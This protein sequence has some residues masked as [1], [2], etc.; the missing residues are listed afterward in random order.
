MTSDAEIKTYCKQ[1]TANLEK[2]AEDEFNEFW[3]MF[4]AKPEAKQI[5]FM[6][7]LFRTVYTCAFTSGG[8]EGVIQ[9]MET[10][11]KLMATQ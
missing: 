11:Q 1:F 10:C 9:V 7:D 2:A 6:R 3:V 5:S 4:Q 8:E